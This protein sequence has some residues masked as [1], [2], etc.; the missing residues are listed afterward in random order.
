M[1]DTLPFVS[2]FTN[3]YQ[4]LRREHGPGKKSKIDAT[5]ELRNLIGANILT[6]WS[7]IKQPSAYK[8]TTWGWQKTSRTEYI[9]RTINQFPGN[10]STC[11][12]HTPSSSNRA[13]MNGSNYEWFDSQTQ[14]TIHPYSAYQKNKAKDSGSFRTSGYSTSTPTSTSTPWRRSANVSGTSAGPACPFS[15]HSISPLDSGRWSWNQNHN[16]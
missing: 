5:L 16:R 14:V 9:S 2:K 1:K 15:Q 11:Q 3:D 4:R 12:K 10:N 13:W 8:N 6:Y 7:S